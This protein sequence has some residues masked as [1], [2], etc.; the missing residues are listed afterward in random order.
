MSKKVSQNQVERLLDLVPYLTSHQGV[1]LEQVAS[2]FHTDK[3]TIIDDLNTLWMCGLPGYTP[4][5]LIDLSFDTGFV[6]I[7]NA[8]VLSKPR[9]FSSLELATVIV[10]LHILRESIHSENPHFELIST[11]LERLSSS[12]S[13]AIPQS[14]Q[15]NVNAEIRSA[16]ARAVREKQ[17]LSIRYHSYTKDLEIERKVF[18]FDLQIIDNHEYL[19]SF[20]YQSN[21]ARLFRLDRIKRAEFL[22]ASEFVPDNINTSESMRTF[23]FIVQSESRKVAETLQVDIPTDH[24]SRSELE[25]SAFNDEWIVRSIC[26][27]NGAATLTAPQILR[28]QIKERAEK[29]LALYA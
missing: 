6:T 18:P 20:C 26:S 25:A 14:M 3:S 1:A 15:S 4:L 24:S 29:A 21:A 7:R 17:N 5:E 12:T 13:V 23:R 27:L 9:K 2:D 28:D 19:E 22:G 8:E 10:G 16:C 11:L